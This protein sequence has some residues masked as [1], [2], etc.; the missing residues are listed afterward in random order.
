MV[1][2]NN[3]KNIGKLD[4]VYKANS[5]MSVSFHDSFTINDYR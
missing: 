3:S 4:A 1:K 5:K 2:N